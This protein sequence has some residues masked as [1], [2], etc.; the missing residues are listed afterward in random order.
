MVSVPPLGGY[1]M[2]KAL[3]TARIGGQRMRGK[4]MRTA[5][6][7]KPSP[8]RSLSDHSGQATVPMRQSANRTNA[9]QTKPLLTRP[10]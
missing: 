4:R 9:V 2:L 6:A 10:D 7:P 3:I 5:R 8:H 1:F